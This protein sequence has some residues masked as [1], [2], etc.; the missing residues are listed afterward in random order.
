VKELPAEIAE[1]VV[2]MLDQRGATAR[3][4]E[5]GLERDAIFKLARRLRPDEVVDF[6]QA[7][8]E[9]E[10]AVDVALDVIA[11]GERGTN[12]DDFVQRVLQQLAE[13]TRRGDFDAGSKLVDESLRRLDEEHR[14]SK[15][16]LLDAGVEQDIL[17]RDAFAVARTLRTDIR[18]GR[19]STI[20]GYGRSMPKAGRKASIFHWK[21]Q[22]NSPAACWL[23]RATPTSAE[24]RGFG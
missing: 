4:A 8:K 6:D 1:R 13:T 3:A 21:S 16:A 12:L 15:E 19:R 24:R 18:L 9:L 20:S 7:V 10:N 11:K 22:S 23:R 2:A 14:A 5:G 17:R